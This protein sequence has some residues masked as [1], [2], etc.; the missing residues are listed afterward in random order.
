MTVRHS[1]AIILPKQSSSDGNR[2]SSRSAVAATLSRKVCRRGDARLESI[3]RPEETPR[4]DR[5]A[6]R[7]LFFF[8]FFSFFFSS[9]LRKPRTSLSARKRH[10]REKIPRLVPRFDSLTE[11]RRAFRRIP[12]REPRD[13][14]ISRR[15][16]ILSTRLRFLR[17]KSQEGSI[18]R[19][20]A[21]WKR[22]RCSR[23]RRN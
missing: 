16:R 13:S 14:A 6:Q 8:F 9:R 2:E 23:S 1:R 3:P 15:A 12:P 21:R 10:A 17:R 4:S 7:D 18:A 20:G 22:Q 11:M 19:N 5:R